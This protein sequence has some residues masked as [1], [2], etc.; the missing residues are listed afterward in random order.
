MWNWLKSHWK[1]LAGI[2]CTAVG[3]GVL[4][5]SPLI[6]AVVGTVCTAVLQNGEAKAV[7]AKAK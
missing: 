7:A 3:V 5:I 4:P 6:T 1:T 2:G